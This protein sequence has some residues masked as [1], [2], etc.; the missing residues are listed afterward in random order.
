MFLFSLK[1]CSVAD[2]CTTETGKDPVDPKSED[3]ISQTYWCGSSQ[4]DVR[5]NV[6][7]VCNFHGLT[8]SF[9]IK[10]GKEYNCS[11]NY[12]NYCSWT[13]VELVTEL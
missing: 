13:F 10:K 2:L 1:T 3:I 4:L 7:F 5:D 11:D 9:S 8:P 12:C 6:K